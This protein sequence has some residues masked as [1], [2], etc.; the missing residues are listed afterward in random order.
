MKRGVLLCCVLVMVIAAACGDEEDPPPPGNDVI[1]AVGG[2]YGWSEEDRGPCVR[3][4]FSQMGMSVD[5]DTILFLTLCLDEPDRDTFFECSGSLYD[6]GSDGDG[7][8]AE[9]D[10]ESNSPIATPPLKNKLRLSEVAI[11]P[12]VCTRDFNGVLESDGSYARLVD[13]QYA[14]G[15]VLVECDLQMTA[16]AVYETIYDP[17]Y[18]RCQSDDTRHEPVT[19]PVTGWGVEEVTFY[20]NAAGKFQDHNGDYEPD[21]V[22]GPD[23]GW[24]PSFACILTDDI[25][26]DVFEAVEPVR[27]LEPGS[28][29]PMP[30][31]S[32]LLGFVRDA[33]LLTVEYTKVE[34]TPGVGGLND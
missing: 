34:N 25:D 6:G 21:I 13:G 24:Y 12:T 2:C 27:C 9:G 7:G 14:A 32:C 22:P 18:I 1:E 23:V 15:E 30:P 10:P 20:A 28:V 3:K 16:T 11:E 19:Y 29:D 4:V 31:D 17:G 26:Q 8:E 5:E 33:A